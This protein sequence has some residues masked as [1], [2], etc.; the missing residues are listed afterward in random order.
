M[1]NFYERNFG[2][3][4]PF[5]HIS[6]HYF[7]GI[8]AFLFFFQFVYHQVS[9][10]NI[11]TFLVA[12]ISVDL[13]GLLTVLIGGK[14]PEFRKTI[15]KEMS[16]LKIRNALTYA[17]KNH[18][19]IDNLSIHKFPF[20]FLFIFSLIVCTYYGLYDFGYILLAFVVH[21]TFDIIGDLKHL[22]NLRHWV[23]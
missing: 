11:S 7:W 9:L 10:L 1:E 13:D 17:T 21:M 18:K 20:Y 23:R 6:Q 19:K 12:T 14:Y 5:R 15:I 22:G 2:L 3:D 4:K 16:K 8:V